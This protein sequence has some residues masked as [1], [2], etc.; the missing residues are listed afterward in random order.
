[1][2][3][4]SESIY[5]STASPFEKPAWGRF[6]KKGRTLYAHVFNWPEDGKLSI[7]A[8]GAQASRAYLLA[9]KE[10]K[11]EIEQTQNGLIIHLPEEAPDAVA[12]VVAI[13]LEN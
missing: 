13:E 4:N 9:D 10:Q 12:S 8:E 2:D 6:T 3:V 1:M 5:G 11:L 7:T